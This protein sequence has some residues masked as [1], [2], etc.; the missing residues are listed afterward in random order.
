[1]K[2]RVTHNNIAALSRNCRPSQVYAGVSDSLSRRPSRVVSRGVGPVVLDCGLQYRE[3]R[4][5]E[6][7][8]ERF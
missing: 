5:S 1:M 8:Q 3:G 7:L 6:N 2:Q 4:L